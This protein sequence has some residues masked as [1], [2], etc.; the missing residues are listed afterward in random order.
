MGMELR[1]LRY[2]VAVAEAGSFTQ[3]AEKR[4]HTAQPSLSRQIRDLEAM[5]KVPLIIREA[6]GLSLTAA[7]RVFLDHARMI[8]AQADAAIEVA[9]RAHKPAKTRFMV[10][11]LTGHEIGWLPQV[12]GAI[13][14]RIGSTELIIHSASSPELLQALVDGQ[15]DI[16]FVRPDETMRELQFMPLIEEELFVLIPADHRLA[17]RQ[18]VRLADIG[19]EP[20]VSI[21]SS[22]S[23]ALRRVI[24][25]CLSG[26]GLD[27]TPVHDAETLPMVI[28]FVLSSQ[29]VALLPAYMRRLLPASVVARPL[30]GRPPTIPLALGYNAHNMPSLLQHLLSPEAGLVPA[31]SSL[32]ERQSTTM[33]ESGYPTMADSPRQITRTSSTAFHPQPTFGAYLKT[34]NN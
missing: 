8:L 34:F 24:D 20:F 26:A 4:L 19:K 1:H 31:T 5:L 22:Y 13:G 6:R 9:R 12:L 33:K 11:F 10:G 17:R 18:T 28:S 23:P 29:G 25:D 2:F 32:P 16:A 21:S 27:V 30:A 7:G 14:S 15:M 3:A